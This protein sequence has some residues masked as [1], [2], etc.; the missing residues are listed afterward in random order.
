MSPKFL[1]EE[2]KKHIFSFLYVIYS[3]KPKSYLN[4]IFDNF[5]YLLQPQN[6]KIFEPYK[7]L[8]I[9]FI[10]NRK[11]IKEEKIEVDRFFYQLDWIPN[12]YYIDKFFPEYDNT[13]YFIL[14]I[15]DSSHPWKI[16]LIP[17]LEKI[18][19][20]SG[21]E[22]EEKLLYFGLRKIKKKKSKKITSLQNILLIKKM[23]IKNEYLPYLNNFLLENFSKFNFKDNNH[24]MVYSYIFSSIDYEMD[25]II[26]IESDSDKTRI[27]ESSLFSLYLLKLNINEIYNKLS[28]LISYAVKNEKKDYKYPNFLSFLQQNTD[29]IPESQMKEYISQLKKINDKIKDKIFLFDSQYSSNEIV[30]KNVV[31][32]NKVLQKN[33]IKFT[34]GNFKE[35][36][37]KYLFNKILQNVIKFDKKKL[38]LLDL[39]LQ[40]K[41]LDD[42]NL[43]KYPFYMENLKD[44]KLLDEIIREKSEDNIHK[45]FYNMKYSNILRKYIKFNK[46]EILNQLKNVRLNNRNIFQYIYEIRRIIKICIDIDS[47]EIFNNYY[48]M[49]INDLENKEKVKKQL[50]IF[51]LKYIFKKDNYENII[52]KI[53][54]S[55]KNTFIFDVVKEI[56]C[57][58]SMT[59][60]KKKFDFFSKTFVKGKLDNYTVFKN[61]FCKSLNIE[62]ALDLIKTLSKNDKIKFLKDKYEELNCSTIYLLLIN[63]CYKILS[64]FIPIIKES[65]KD[66]KE[67]LYPLKEKKEEKKEEEKEE[68][69]EEEKEEKEEENNFYKTDFNF[70]ECFCNFLKYKTYP[71]IAKENKVKENI[72]ELNIDL[73]YYLSHHFNCFECLALL[74]DL[75][76]HEQFF[77]YKWT[78]EWFLYYLQYFKTN[79]RIIKQLS[80]NFYQLSLTLESIYHKFKKLNA[81]FIPHTNEWNLFF[82]YIHI[83]IFG[84]NFTQ[85][86]PIIKYYSNKFFIDYY[87]SI[88]QIYLSLFSFYEIKGK[89]II[90]IKKYFPNFYED[91]NKYYDQFNSLKINPFPIKIPMND[92]FMEEYKKPMTFLLVLYQTGEYYVSNLCYMIVEEYKLLNQIINL[93]NERALIFIELLKNKDYCLYYFLNNYENLK[94]QKFENMFKFMTDVLIKCVK[95]EEDRPLIL[96][97]MDEYNIFC[98]YLSDFYQNSKNKIE[99]ED[100]DFQSYKSDLNTIIYYCHYIIHPKNQYIYFYQEIFSNANSKNKNF[101]NLL[102]ELISKFKI[103]QISKL[104]I[105]KV[106]DKNPNIKFLEVLEKF[107]DKFINSNHI[108]NQIKNFGKKPYLQFFNYLNLHC[109]FLLELIRILTEDIKKINIENVLLLECNDKEIA[110]KTLQNA[111][112][113]YTI[114]KIIGNTKNKIEIPYYFNEETLDFVETNTN[115]NLAI[116]FENEFSQNYD[117]YPPFYLSTYKKDEN[118][119]YLLNETFN[120]ILEGKFH[121]YYNDHLEL[122]RHYFLD[123]EYFMNCLEKFFSRYYKKF[124][125][126]EKEKM[127]LKDIIFPSKQ[128]NDDMIYYFYDSL[129]YDY[130]IPI[131]LYYFDKRLLSNIKDSSIHFFSNFYKDFKNYCSKNFLFLDKHMSNESLNV[132][133][134]KY[135]LSLDTSTFIPQFYQKYLPQ[136]LFILEYYKKFSRDIIGIKKTLPIYFSFN[137]KKLIDTIFESKY[138]NDSNYNSLFKIRAINYILLNN[139]S[140]FRITLNNLMNEILYIQQNEVSQ[141]VDKEYE[142]KPVKEIKIEEIKPYKFN[143]DIFVINIDSV[144]KRDINLDLDMDK[145]INKNKQ[146]NSNKKIISRQSKFRFSKNYGQN[147]FNYLFNIQNIKFD[148]KTNIINISLYQNNIKIP[149]NISED[150]F[151]ELVNQT[152]GE[153]NINKEWSKWYSPNNIYKII[154]PKTKQ[155]ETKNQKPITKKIGHNY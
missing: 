82:L 107:Y 58:I 87:G 151:L 40:F 55:N 127:E 124:N 20:L 13:F 75:Y 92:L 111:M 144:K 126:R 119:E 46:E 50:I 31:L 149:Q 97:S 77:L 115:I 21:K 150:T 7:K 140:F 155:P 91:V 51:I 76:S 121:L 27:K 120:K 147:I 72:S 134:K 14:S 84:N 95:D 36:I 105:Q 141:K 138:F 57:I 35:N 152:Y 122:I 90:S 11:N 3:E 93:E 39:I 74:F 41:D 110:K 80:N 113:N 56:D 142:E 69:E 94:K 61:C 96:S 10:D 1:S 17:E 137:F 59:N 64:E 125:K 42:F 154:F 25:R 106:R 83:F 135:Y 116:F 104:L 143:K 153:K 18:K 45:L 52:S 19:K 34:P 131:I 146:M 139:N 24:N 81:D 85:K 53:S 23:K 32:F 130:R 43:F 108:K 132:F 62:L 117:D 26:N 54:K 37:R 73:L 136:Y 100:D 65:P 48:A 9:D 128:K 78:D 8:F 4:Q 33:N 86:F 47:M 6:K 133:Q 109:N 5:I 114:L 98:L 99:K 112:K 88:E 129:F 68:K 30:Y 16:D 118:F 12:L 145:I 148:D 38:E 2:L 29:L 15:F 60:S 123:E 103:K 71:K 89:T 63:N 49:I 44:D 70:I 22:K 102:K 67:I 66:Y 101:T 79:K 28:E